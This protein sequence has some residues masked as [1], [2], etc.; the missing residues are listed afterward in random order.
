MTSKIDLVDLGI[1]TT[2][3]KAKFEAGVLYGPPGSGKSHF[4]LSIAQSEKYSPVLVVDTENSVS[5]VIDNF[6]QRDPDDPKDIE[7]DPK[8]G[9]GIIDVVRPIELWGEDAYENTF[10]LLNAVADGKTIY[11]TVIIDVVD[12]LQQWGLAYHNDTKNTYHK[13]D[14][15]DRDLTGSP[16][17][18][19]DGRPTGLFYRLKMSNVFAVFVVHEKK[20]VPEG[21]GAGAVSDFQWQGQGKGK[22]GGIPDVVFYFKRLMQGKKPVTKMYT[23]GTGRF[24]AKN[25]FNLEH[26]YVNPTFVQ[27][28]EDAKKP[29]KVVQEDA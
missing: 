20:E 25:R 13:W 3:E 16:L 19:E 2:V 28:L 26:E 1:S 5:G 29:R 4:A 12:V 21:D 24:L 23:N 9:G 14:M 27:V 22:L 7:F 6:R 18:S 8:K 17:P 10:D 11:N 15:I